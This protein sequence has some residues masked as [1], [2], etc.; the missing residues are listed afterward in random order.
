MR[1]SVLL[2]SHFSDSLHAGGLFCGREE[3]LVGKDEANRGEHGKHQVS[4]VWKEDEL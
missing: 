4:E 2:V 3:F 1:A